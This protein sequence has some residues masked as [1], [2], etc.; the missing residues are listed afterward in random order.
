MQRRPSSPRDAATVLLLRP[1]HSGAAP[2]EVFMV[3]RHGKSRFM[4]GMYVFPGGKRDEGDSTPEVRACCRGLTATE[5]AAVLGDLEPERALGHFVAALRETFEEAGVLLTHDG[6]WDDAEAVGAARLALHHGE[7]TIA[8]LATRYGW[9]LDLSQ[10]RYLDHWITPEIEPRR[11]SA[12]FFM[13][14]VPA[15]QEARHDALETTDGVW[16]APSMALDQYYERKLDMVPPTIKV[17]QDIAERASIDEA[18][19]ACPHGPIPAKAPR[20]S[21]DGSIAR[22]VLPGDPDHPTEPGERR[23]RFELRDG[24]WHIAEDI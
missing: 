3:R 24:R 9:T 14:A 20:L 18:L 1:A 5:A 4:G 12:R 10:L 21:M 15:G 16:I 8:S 22:L 17:L 7:T 6:P 19:A 23:R 13:A 11:F 2:F